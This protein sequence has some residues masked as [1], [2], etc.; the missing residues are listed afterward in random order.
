MA[1]VSL[2]ELIGEETWQKSA[3][4]TAAIYC[5][6]NIDV[7]Q[8]IQVAKAR[9]LAYFVVTGA[10]Y[11]PLPLDSGFVASVTRCD[12]KYSTAGRS[13]VSCK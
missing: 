13:K 3:S 11:D 5:N 1:S 7:G 2:K 6:V 9:G 10:D 4:G 8:G 12:V